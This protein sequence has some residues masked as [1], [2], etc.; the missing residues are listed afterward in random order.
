MPKEK[1]TECKT[2]RL[3]DA[4]H[5]VRSAR[6]LVR[7]ERAVEAGVVDIGIDTVA[8]QVQPEAARDLA[9][10]VDTVAED[11]TLGEVDRSSVFGVDVD[12]EDR[13]GDG[14]GR[15]EGDESG[16]ELHCDD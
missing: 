16:E 9:V 7:V 4:A 1:R 5:D 13:E 10:A 8:M 12:F 15:E 14:D 2:N 3:G 11:A 6:A